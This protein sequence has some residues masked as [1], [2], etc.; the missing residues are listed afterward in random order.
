MQWNNQ[1]TIENKK[2]QTSTYVETFLCFHIDFFFVII[3]FAERKF[4]DL[5]I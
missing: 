3:I 1:I 5:Q 4:G 2:L